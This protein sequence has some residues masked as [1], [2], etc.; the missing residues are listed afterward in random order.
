MASS[1]KVSNGTL[2]PEAFGGKKSILVKK[3]KGPTKEKKSVSFA[4]I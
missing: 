3:N 4:E 1:S 2:T